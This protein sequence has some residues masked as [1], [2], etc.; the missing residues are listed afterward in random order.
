LVKETS[1]QVERSFGSLRAELQIA[2]ARRSIAEAESVAKLTELAFLFIPL[3]FAA[4]LF[5]MQ[6]K[7]LDPA[8][9]VSY[10][11]G[12]S[13]AV[14]SFSYIMR[15]VVRSSILRQY[16]QRMF[17][18]IHEHAGVQEG[19]SITT[20]QFLR[21]ATFWILPLALRTV[22]LFVA[23]GISIVPLVFLWRR[24]F[25]TGYSIIIT[26]LV[27]PMDLTLIWIFIALISDD[28]DMPENW[29]TW[30][31]SKTRQGRRAGSERSLHSDSSIA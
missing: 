17:A 15:L 18:R 20:R 3:T 22:F 25:D 31:S 27:V 12:T 13:I 11:I 6:V 2:E 9:P 21:G 14:I 19:R 24:G 28:T 4:G 1:Q 16:R 30:I 7:E 10:F 8:P 26:L 5:S 23:F 29:R